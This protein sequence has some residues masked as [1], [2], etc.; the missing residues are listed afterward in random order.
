VRLI[1]FR[2]DDDIVDIIS[3][4]FITLFVALLKLSVCVKMKNL[5]SK[6]AAKNC[7]KKD[8]IS[9]LFFKDKQ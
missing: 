3:I 1:A 7:T 4:R 2:K 8:T 6:T 5:D 9:F